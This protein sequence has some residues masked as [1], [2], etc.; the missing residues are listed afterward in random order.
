ML[1]HIKNEGLGR[2]PDYWNVTFSGFNT[3][4]CFFTKDAVMAAPRLL[5][6]TIFPDFDSMLCSECVDSHDRITVIIKDISSSRL[7]DAFKL[8]AAGNPEEVAELLEL[9]PSPMMIRGG[10]QGRVGVQH[11]IASAP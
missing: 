3:E 1:V 7:E 5:I 9:Q 8:L 4:V 2:I 6:R 10:V 11:K